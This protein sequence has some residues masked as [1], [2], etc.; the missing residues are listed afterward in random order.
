MKNLMVK[1]LLAALLMTLLAACQQTSTADESGEETDA[2]QEEKTLRILTSV[3]GGKTPEE[4]AE[5]EKEIERL[6][7]ISV[8]IEKVPTDYDQRLLTSMSAGEQ[9]DL[10]YMTKPMMD[11]LVDQGAL[12][13]LTQ[14][15]QDSEILS[16]PTVIPT[17]EWEL[18]TYDDGKIYS[19][20]NKFEGGTMP[21][22]RQ[23]WLEALGLEEPTTLDDYY[24]VLKAFTEQDPNGTG[25]DDTYGLTTAGLYDIQ[26][27]MSAAGVKARYVI[28]DD[29]SRTIPYA[30][31]AAI[32]VYEWFAKLYEEGIL[33]P[34]FATNDSG[35]MQELFLSDRV[36]V[37]TYWD[38]WV[39][40]FN[41]IRLN[42][43]PNTSFMAKG[44]PGAPDENGEFMLR[45][46]DPSVW[47]IPVNA[48]HPETALEFLEFWHTPEG[49]TVSTLGVK[50]LH[51]TVD[52]NGEYEL[53]ELGEIANMDHGVV[54]PNNT[55]WENPFGTLPGVEE[56]QAI[57]IEHAQPEV[58][59]A[60]WPQAEK[61]VERYVF[62]AITGDMPAPEAVE[63]MHGE[64]LAAD[65]IDN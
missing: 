20:F 24:Q 38:A 60:D 64:L 36:G 15:I 58:S 19:V 39:G 62:A 44:L 13:E 16:D 29:G 34:N 47:A 23:D 49:N 33:D 54:F 5:F 46:G 50:D 8:T 21:L 10:V 63:R 9:Y 17:E 6:T 12:T 28:E 65:L 18:I 55:N 11:V 52:E 26:G 14:S 57:I 41:N 7:G 25:Q 40:L 56:A 1:L 48:E 53:T 43:D 42:D 61:I 51:Y 2:E 31:E 30:T 4:H 27:F 3:V 37:V 35:N 59:T 45:R 32:P 22:I